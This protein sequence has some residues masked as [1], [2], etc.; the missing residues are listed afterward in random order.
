MKYLQKAL[1]ALLGLSQQA[2]AQDARSGAAQADPG[3]TLDETTKRN[4]AQALWMK[5]YDEKAIPDAI[6]SKI[7][8]QKNSSA[9]FAQRFRDRLEEMRRHPLSFV[10]SREK[11]YRILL[12]HAQSLSPGQF[13]ARTHLLGPESVVGYDPIPARPKFSFPAIDAPQWNNQVGWHFFVGN[14]TDTA[15]NHYGV[16]MMFWQYALLPAAFAR[17]HGLSEIE[18]QVVEI[19]LAIGDESAGIHYSA[20]TVLVAGT[21][22]LID[23]TPAPYTYTVGRNSIQGTDPSGAMFPLR[24]QARGWDMGKNSGLEMEIDISL[25]DQKGYFLQGEDGCWPSVDGVGTLYYSASSLGLKTDTPSFLR[26][27]DR[28]VDLAGGSM[29]YDHQW[30]TGF[31]PSGAPRHAVMRAVQNLTEPAPGGWDW[32]MFQF[33]VDERIGLKREVALTLSALHNRENLSFYRQNGETVPGPMTTPCVGKYIDP[34]NNSFEIKGTM[35]VDQWVRS[36][37]TPNPALYPPTGFWYPGRYAFELEGELPDALKRFWGRPLVGGEQTNFFATGLQYSEGAAVLFD[38]KGKELGR[39][40]A[41]H[42]D[43]ADT[44]ETVLAL[45]G[46]PVN[47]DTLLF[48]KRPPVPWL[49]K[50]CSFLYAALSR[51]ELNRILAEAKGM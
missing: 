50:Q 2:L 29:W 30:G 3:E 4:I 45:A 23:F 31:M 14:V 44:G 9:A 35:K 41:E 20:N 13:Y 22:G 42:T 16:Q 8:S 46:L 1:F 25:E 12:D 5:E 38:D 32:F 11:R 6:L 26:I 18:N 37:A 19:H 43:Y 10:P 47:A 51:K 21:T 28:K 24:L 34:D 49:M 17:K 15:G 27:G 36:A 39:G 40:F 33:P 7:K 48:L